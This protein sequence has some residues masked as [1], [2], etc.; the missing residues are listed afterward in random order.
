MAD[1]QAES[2]HALLAALHAERERSWAPEDLQVNIEQRRRLVAEA[3]GRRFPQPGDRL[4]AAELIDVERG[5]FTLKGPAVL[6]FF[7]FAGCPACN[8]ALPYYGRQ[9]A[10]ALRAFGVPLIAIS[11]QIPERLHEI[12]ERHALDFTVASDPD[13]AFG[14]SLGILYSYDEASRQASQRKGRPIGEVTGTGTWELPMPAAIVVDA[15][16]IVHFA[17]VSPDWLVR[18]EA[19]PLID[20]VRALLPA[21][22]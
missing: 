11:P 16:R 18:T 8:I 1:P 14:R 20:A 7:R 19:T 10:P 6:V 15:D 3:A 9:L 22:A 12:R 13:N 21:A 5:P 2:L 4:E 17:E